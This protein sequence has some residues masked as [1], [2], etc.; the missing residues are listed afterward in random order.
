MNWA[1]I[2]SQFP[3]FTKYP[4]LVYLDSAA[5]SQKPEAVIAA[6]TKFYTEQ[7]ANVHR[8]LYELSEIA[9]TEYEHARAQV[10]SLLGVPATEFV[11]T[12]GTTAGANMVASSYFGTRLEAGDVVI[13]SLA[14]HHSNYLPWQRLVAAKNAKLILTKLTPERDFDYEQFRELLEQYG[15]NIKCIVLSAVSNVLGYKLDLELIVS[16]RAK[17][18]PTALIAIDAAQ[19]IGHHPCRPSELGLDFCYFSGHKMFAATGIGGFWARTE[20]LQ[21]MDPYLVGG[22]MIRNVEVSG[23]EYADIPAKFEAGTPDI[24]GAISL[25]VAAEFISKLGIEN[26]EIQ[27]QKLAKQ[28]LEKL[29]S[30]P[31][32]QLFGPLD[33]TKRSTVFSFNVK[34]IHPHDLASFLGSRN[35]AL[36]AGHHCA[37]ILHREVIENTGS[38]RASLHI[39]NTAE[40]LDKLTAGITAAIEFFKR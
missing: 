15:A 2:K 40:D 11:F 18:A 7:N 30:I 22:G 27:Q 8:G 16:L 21:K 31:E 25:G 1:E 39:Y 5:T 23:T 28:A 19:L 33:V 34:D 10:A 12:S 4:E 32:L 36:R 9:T 14:E 24:A 20:L 37:Q 6:I 17:Y 29:A 26:I 13:T 3:I 35:I 38:V